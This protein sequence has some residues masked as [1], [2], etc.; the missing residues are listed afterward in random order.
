MSMLK[1]VLAW[2]WPFWRGRNRLMIIVL[3]L[4]AVGVA[5]RTAYPLLYKFVLDAITGGARIA[6]VHAWILALLGG[7]ILQQG[8][9]LLLAM[10]RSTGNSYLGMDIRMRSLGTVLRKTPVFYRRFRSGDLITRLTSDVDSGAKLSWFSCSGVMRPLEAGLTLGMSVAVMLSL[11]WRLTLFAV[12]PLPLTVFLAIRTRRVQER[13]YAER[14]SRTSETVEVLDT[15]FN[16]LRIVLSYVAEAAQGRLFD[17]VLK[18]RE[19]SERRVLTMDALVEAIGITLNR[20]GV[21][22]VLFV[23][24][25]YLLQG[26]IT[27]GEFYAF[28]TYLNGLAHPMWT[29]AN[30]FVNTSQV[31][32]SMDRIIEL[33]Q[34]PV[35]SDHGACAGRGGRLKVED[36]VF[37]LEDGTKVLSGIGLAVQRGEMVALVGPVGCGKSTLLDLAAGLLP[38]SAGQV[39]LDGVPVNE[40]ESTRRSGW[41]GYVPQENLLFSG[42]VAENVSMDREGIDA[43]RV[44]QSL[45]TACVLDEFPPE[46]EIAQ[47][48]VGLSGGQ[49]ARVAIARALAAKP[50]I[51][52]LDDVTS[53]LDASTEQRFWLHLR[54]WLP[55]TGVLVS[56]HR[57]ATARVADRV[58]WLDHGRILHSGRHEDLLRAHPDYMELFAREDPKA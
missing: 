56:T 42:T 27:L 57:E 34:Q 54:R 33:E 17:G 36:L 32:A 3:V 16:G 8:S 40:L 28:M 5:S 15:A 30:L 1:R 43:E 11:D 51:L 50:D 18:H 10:S 37:Q 22:M 9:Q 2:Y 31:A 20:S 21:I 38:P 35:V 4:T 24:G 48:G 7:A 44:R 53:A 58:L 41:L 23:G 52:L 39:T 25:Y 45:R 47:G 55:D 29:L 26:R 49:R 19:R 14:Q 12:L 46:R 6:T 13:L